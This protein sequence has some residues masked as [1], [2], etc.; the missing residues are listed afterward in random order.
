VSARGMKS[1]L[2]KLIDAAL[3]QC[4]TR[5]VFDRDADE[6]PPLPCLRGNECRCQLLMIEEVIVNT[7]EE[8]RAI[9]ACNEEAHREAAEGC[10]RVTLPRV[11]ARRGPDPAERDDF[12]LTR[13]T[14]RERAELSRLLS[15][16]SQ[17]CPV[18]RRP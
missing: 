17:L 3:P 9:L 18:C 4:G 14:K 13:L 11:R 2:A 5:L 7:P 16:A 12:D 15:A 6:P 1:K 8:V 10:C